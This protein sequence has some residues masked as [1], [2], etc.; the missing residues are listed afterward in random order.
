MRELERCE[1]EIAAKFDNDDTLTESGTVVFTSGATESNYLAITGSLNSRGNR[2]SSIVTTGMEHK[3]VSAAVAAAAQ[4]HGTGNIEVITLPPPRLAA[5]S[6]GTAVNSGDYESQI[7]SAV[8]GDTVLVSCMAVNNETGFCIDTRR[9]YKELK[10]KNPRCVFHTDAAAGFTKTDVY[11]DLVSFSAHKF[12]GIAGVGG[13]FIRKGVRVRPV[14]AGGGQQGGLRGGTEPVALISAMTAA[15]GEE[16][17]SYDRQVVT[18]RDSGSAL[19]SLLVQKAQG[20]DGVSVNYAGVNIV[21]LCV[22]GAKSQV[23]VNALSERGIYVSAGSA[24]NKGKKSEVLLAMGFAPATVDGTLRVSFGRENTA[25]EVYEFAD[26][27]SEVG[28]I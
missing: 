11:G 18:P 17:I 14:M 10:Q 3:S 9:L 23:L 5:D 8:D 4:T 24:C 22:H 7:L 13:L 15:A 12:G 26:A 2:T 27:L 25:E 6:K 28:I 19:T 20:M 21:S 16:H 1:R